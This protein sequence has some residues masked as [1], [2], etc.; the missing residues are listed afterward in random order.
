MHHHLVP[1]FI[2]ENVAAGR[3]AGALD[4]VC[5]FVDT[6]GFTPLTTAMMARGVEGAEAVAD[7]LAAVFEP[8]AAIVYAHGGFIAAFA[9][10]AFKAIF[11]LDQPDAHRRA[12]AAAWEIRSQMAGRP[13][14]STPFGVFDVAVK[15]TLAD[16]KVA[17]GVWLS[18]D[19]SPFT[20]NRSPSQ[21]ALYWFEG[22]ALARCM[23][24]DPLAA[25]GEV[26]LTDAVLRRL[27]DDG[28][29]VAAEPVDGHWRLA[30]LEAGDAASPSPRPPHEAEDAPGGAWFYPADLLSMPVRGE[31]RRVVT[32]F[33]NLAAMPEDG[34]FSDGLFRLLAQ[35]RGYLCRIGRIG[36]RDRGATLLLFWGA[37]LSHENDL[38][39][40]L[41]FLLDLRTAHPGLALRAGVAA[42]LAYAGF[43]GSAQREEYTCHGVTVNLAARL[44]VTAGWGEIWLDEETA[45][46]AQGQFDLDPAGRRQLKGFAAPRPL[47]RLTGR[48]ETGEAALY[49]GSMVGRQ[50]ELDQLQAALAPLAEGRFAGVITVLGEAGLGK[51]RL[52]YELRELSTVNSQLS[53][54]NAESPTTS[55]SSTI[56]HSPLTIDNSSWFFCPCDDVLRQSLN[57]FRY[58]LRRHFDQSG[59]AGED[60]NKSRFEQALDQLI[61]ATS[62]AAL[63]AELQRTRSVLGA[64]LDLRWDGSLYE[65][66]DPQGR[67]DNTLLALKAL[68]KAES[69]RRPLV[70]HVE[71]AHWLD[72]DSRLFL[73]RLARN[74]A[75]YPFA[76]LLTARPE[77]EPLT[78][79]P[80]TVQHTVLLE[81]MPAADLGHLAGQVLGQPAAPALVALLG[82]RAE[83]NPFFA[84]QLLFYLRERGLLTASPG[85]LAPAG[86][87]VADAVPLDVRAV[88]VARIDRLAAE[89]RRVVQTAAVL[90]REFELRVL[91]AMLAGQVDVAIP[92]REAATAAIWTALSELR[93]LFRHALLRDA[94]YTM[95]LLAARRELHRLAGEAMEQLYA[96]DL[97]PHYGQLA[98]HFE[99]AGVSGQARLYLAQAGDQAAQHYHNAAID[100][101]RRL[102]DLLDAARRADPDFAATPAALDATIKLADVLMTASRWDESQAQLERAMDLAD[103]SGDAA[104]RA[105]AQALLG[106]LS[107]HRGELSLAQHQL[108]Q[109]VAAMRRAGLIDFL[110][111]ALNRLGTAF[112]R[113]GDGAA[114]MA[115]FDEA[116]ALERG[117]SDA[118]GAAMT[119]AHMAS[120]WLFR[121][122]LPVA[123]EHLQEAFRLYQSL[124]RPSVLGTMQINLA[125]VYERMG[126][127][128]LALENYG[129]ALQLGRA[130]GVK[131]AVTRCLGNMGNLLRQLGRFDDAQACFL[132][133]MQIDQE[134]GSQR[135]VAWHYANLGEL[136]CTRGDY[137]QAVGY[138]EQALPELRARGSKKVFAEVFLTYGEALLALRRVAEARS[139]Q[140]EAQALALETGLP[141]LLNQSG[142]LGA[143]LN[144]AEG[145][146]AAAEAALRAMLI[147]AQRPVEQAALHYELW[148]LSG[149]RD[150]GQAALALYRSLA[151]RTANIVYQQRLLEL[152]S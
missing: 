96:A 57:P 139:V 128:E 19:R 92:V 17:W 60:E 62:E 21:R 30:R 16:G 48:R 91:Q 114:A 67:F 73:A 77:W 129:R 45:R 64:L 136:A 140:Q 58:W 109:A 40:A 151:V 66:L 89:V 61:A 130:L 135:D 82:E 78:L 23:E 72:A 132:E 50:S 26:V 25:A 4:A 125:L 5:L 98:Y 123:L 56:D 36:E 18:A 65:Q 38:A 121:G 20:D 146:L 138:F 24:A 108:G 124:G 59:G 7:A 126:E 80:A 54:A 83:G 53:M 133:A 47:F 101:Y 150:H 52:A 100:H 87:A 22:D 143:R 145:D 137:G 95:Q 94:A 12:A 111:Q 32:V 76:I 88:L 148:R 142:I 141:G 1:P 90:G 11:P 41:G 8:L 51:S 68:I 147:A 74:V 3:L 117:R 6:S 31:F 55:A 28:M 116:L 69:L 2:L 42:G 43:I 112:W 71:D 79:E 10:D 131:D 34:G 118:A 81:P 144:A 63:A 46:Q 104:A 97:A 110:P 119:L 102:L 85:G 39:R 115:C 29:A 49:R 122:E 84:E 113:G 13:Q 103:S 9:G 15:A 152:A 75:G 127:D 99:Q 120:V 70:L 106:F 149:A 14:M 37:P 105:R 86:G 44:M 35:Y 107:I 33:L 93:Y 27:I 134:R